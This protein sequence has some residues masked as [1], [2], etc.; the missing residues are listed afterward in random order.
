MPST[1]SWVLSLVMQTCSG[2]SSGTSFSEWTYAMRSKN[3]MMRFNPGSSVLSKRPRRSTTHALCC[4]TMRTPSMRNATSTPMSSTQNQ[5]P[6][7]PGTCVATIVAA[8]ATAS[9]QSMVNSP[10]WWDA[11]AGTAGA[12]F[13]TGLA[14]F[15]RVAIG[16]EYV[17]GGAG[18]ERFRAFDA[19][20][21]ARAA[22]AHAGEAGAG[23]DP[24]LEAGRHSGVDRRHLP[25]AVPGAVGVHAVA[26]GRRN[27]AGDERLHGKHKAQS[28]GG[29]RA[30]GRD[31]EHQQVERS[32]EELGDDEHQAEHPPCQ[33]SFHTCLMWHAGSQIATER[34]LS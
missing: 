33:P 27:H 17:D 34:N 16:G 1:P 20:V 13:G 15:E 18:L 30:K 29:G 5:W 31:T 14:N 3:G 2:T 32:G 12:L 24:A 10:F 4:G 21:P 6:A 23:V 19:G 11:T 8:T 22:I 9:F 7:R 28:R 25:S 26:A